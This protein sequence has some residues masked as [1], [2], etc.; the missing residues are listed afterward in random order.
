MRFKEKKTEDRKYLLRDVRQELDRIHHR[1]FPALKVFQ[2]IPC[3]CPLC[4]V[5]TDPS[6]YDFDM[7]R[8]MEKKHVP[9]AQCS[10]SHAMVSVQQLMSGV[11]PSDDPAKK[12]QAKKIYFSYAW[13]DD[14]ERG[15]S[16]EKIVDK[17]YQSLKKGGF[18][19]LRDKMDSHYGDMISSFM[20]DIGQGDLIVVFVSD[21]YVRSPYCMNELYEIARNNKFDKQLFTERVLPVRVEQIKFD[22]PVILENYFEHWEQEE[23]KWT[24][25]IKKRFQKVTEAQSRRYH[26]VQKIN[27]NFGELSDWLT[28]INAYT[29]ELLSQNNCEKVKEVIIA[30]FKSNDD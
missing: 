25:F 18:N 11:F 24:S 9:S 28:D 10:R 17:L 3:C 13:G 7:L 23:Q 16:R 21:K 20:Q 15:E 4:S 1:S 5:D 8:D 22:D 19:V 14:E 26:I 12:T 27:N 6:E 30:R 2:K 29:N